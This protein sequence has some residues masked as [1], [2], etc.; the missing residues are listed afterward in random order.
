MEKKRDV[1]KKRNGKVTCIS[2]GGR[3]RG[4]LGGR[5]QHVVFRVGFRQ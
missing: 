4:R 5:S 3:E 1:K 2:Q